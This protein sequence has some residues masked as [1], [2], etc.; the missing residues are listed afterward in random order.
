MGWAGWSPRQEGISSKKPW[1][2]EALATVRE[3]ENVKTACYQSW[4]EGSQGRSTRSKSRGALG[5]RRKVRLRHA[6]SGSRWQ[7]SRWGGSPQELTSAFL[8][9]S[10]TCWWPAREQ[11]QHRRDQDTGCLQNSVTCVNTEQATSLRLADQSVYWKLC[12][13]R[14]PLYFIKTV[15]T[16][17]AQVCIALR[18]LYISHI[19]IYISW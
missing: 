10:A 4:E 18:I 8:H 2:L 1:R 6:R 3:K 11:F 5:K 17:Y 13:F 7:E 15:W 9:V 14:E 12:R 19:C 16:I